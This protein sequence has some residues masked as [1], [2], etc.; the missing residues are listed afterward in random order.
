MSEFINVSKIKKL[1]HS[2]KR[3]VSPD[4]LEELDAAT[5]AYVEKICSSAGSM[6]TLGK[7]SVYLVSHSKAAVVTDTRADLRQLLDEVVTMEMNVNV[8]TRDE[9]LKRVRS[10]KSI[11]EKL[12][13]TEPK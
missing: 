6:V 8:V 4:F 10:M 3:R 12:L 11:C 9:Y 7:E 1:V 13:T 2:C 5:K